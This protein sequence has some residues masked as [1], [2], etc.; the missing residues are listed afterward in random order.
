MDPFRPEAPFCSFLFYFHL[1]VT[2]RILFALSIRLIALRRRHGMKFFYFTDRLYDVNRFSPA[3]CS[4][5]ALSCENEVKIMLENWETL[6]SA[7][8]FQ[9]FHVL[10]VKRSENSQTKQNVVNKSSKLPIELSLREK[11][12]LRFCP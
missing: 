9:S 5:S 11:R 6:F 3:V 2:S 4:I 1:F 12:N 7:W 10:Q 8:T